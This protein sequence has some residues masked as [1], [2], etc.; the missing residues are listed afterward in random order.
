[1]NFCWCLLFW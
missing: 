1:M